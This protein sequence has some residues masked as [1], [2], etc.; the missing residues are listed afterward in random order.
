MTMMMMMLWS[1]FS[2]LI[3][4]GQSPWYLVGSKWDSVTIDVE[5]IVVVPDD[6]PSAPRIEWRVTN[7]V[8]P[9]YTTDYHHVG[10]PSAATTNRRVNEIG[11][12]DSNECS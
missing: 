6:R 2:T 4:Y 9:W 11:P 8:V 7:L 12:R 5:G 3:W 10:T 1:S